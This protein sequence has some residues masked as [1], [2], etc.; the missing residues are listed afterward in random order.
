[1]NDITKENKR[2]IAEDN[3]SQKRSLNSQMTYLR[4]QHMLVMGKNADKRFDTC[5]RGFINVDFALW[6]KNFLWF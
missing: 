3:Q 4:G 2:I 6:N 5:N 1:M